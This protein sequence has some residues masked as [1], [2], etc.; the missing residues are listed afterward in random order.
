MQHHFLHDLRSQFAQRANQP[1]LH[2][3]GRSFSYG[4]L[5]AQARCWASWF[6]ARGVEVGDR[7]A[8]YTPHK[9]PFLAAHL[10]TLYAGAVSLPLNPRF[11]REEMRYFLADSG[12]RV[13]V[14]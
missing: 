3:G 4:D 8:L 13:V 10:G 12:P 11:T 14:V 2:Y 6:Q 1:A 9:F 5:E 7:V